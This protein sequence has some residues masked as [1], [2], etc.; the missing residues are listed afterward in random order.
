MRGQNSMGIKII[1]SRLEIRR[2]AINKI[3]DSFASISLT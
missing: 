2:G 3:I 1:E